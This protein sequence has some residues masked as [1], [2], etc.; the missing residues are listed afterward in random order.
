MTTTATEA[1]RWACQPWVQRLIRLGFATKGLTYGL[2]GILALQAVLGL[3]GQ[4]TGAAGVL[5]TILQR[6][7]GSLLLGIVICGML[8]YALWSIVRGV[9]NVDSCPRTPLGWAKRIGYTLVALP[10]LALAWSGIMLLFGGYAQPDNSA[11][12]WTA[13]VLSLPLGVWLVGAVGG[14]FG[15]AAV[16]QWYRAWSKQFTEI[17]DFDHT[18]ERWGTLLFW[19][20]RIGL[21]ARGIV[22]GMIGLFLVRAALED[23]PAQAEGLGGTLRRLARQPFGPPALIVLATGLLLYGVH[24]LIQAR[25]RR[26]EPPEEC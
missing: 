9:L 19:I 22:F 6:R 8:G 16:V 3:G 5:Q 26:I 11:S 1:R 7:S 21:M 14:G 18:T 13:W 10:Y 20:S 4:Y 15:I 23:N 24:A 25:Y 2:V 17:L 12:S